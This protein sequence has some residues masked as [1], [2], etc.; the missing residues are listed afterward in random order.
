MLP[1]FETSRCAQPA[2]VFSL[3]HIVKITNEF[4][5]V[6]FFTKFEAIFKLKK[7][8]EFY[9]KLPDEL[10]FSFGLLISSNLVIKLTIA[11]MHNLNHFV[12]GVCIS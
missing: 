8:A 11:L 3:N 6:I 10:I 9:S 4:D 2:L 12:L 1:E 5:S 7:L